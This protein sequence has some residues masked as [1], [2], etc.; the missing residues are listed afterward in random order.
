MA[1][2]MISYDLNQLG[3]NYSNLFEAIKALGT[4]WH[5]LDSTWIVKSNLTASGIRDILQRHIDSN[6]KLIVVRLTGE[7]A[8]TNSFG[9]NCSNWLKNNL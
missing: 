1:A 7:A 9:A 5:C 8:W 4:W 2:F 6:D 3:Q